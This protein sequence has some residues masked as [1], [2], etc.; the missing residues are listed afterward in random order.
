MQAA[1]DADDFGDNGVPSTTT[2]TGTTTTAQR[3]DPGP[4][5]DTSVT[6]VSG[7]TTGG[8][9]SVALPGDRIVVRSY[10][11]I[12]AGIS[13]TIRVLNKAQFPT[14]PGAPVIALIFQIEARDGVGNMLNALPAEVNLSAR[15][16]NSEIPGLDKNRATFWWYNAATAQWGPAPKLVV[17][18]IFNFV[19]TSTT[20]L[21]TY[22]VCL[23]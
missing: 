10:P 9:S 21:G 7:I 6:Q 22:C 5:F 15:Y 18:P 12:P 13:I 14:Q 2:G 3:N 20:G 23:P 11:G 4:I 19:S 1:V 17:D 16:M 8:E